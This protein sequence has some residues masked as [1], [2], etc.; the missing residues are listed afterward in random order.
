VTEGDILDQLSKFK[1]NTRAWA[2]LWILNGMPW[3]DDK[4]PPYPKEHHVITESLKSFRKS[5]LNAPEEVMARVK[6]AVTT[7]QEEAPIATVV[8]LQ[9]ASV[10]ATQLIANYIK[11]RNKIAELKEAFKTRATPIL[12]L[13]QKIEGL[14][15][16]EIDK[17]GSG[18]GGSL[19]TDNGTAFTQVE[20]SATVEDWAT[21]LKH[22]QKHELWELLE[23]RVAKGAVLA[24]IEE[25]RQ[26]VEARL[27]TGAI[28]KEE[29]TEEIKR[30]LVPG[31]K[32]SQMRVLRVRTA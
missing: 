23:R 1:S 9:T 31:V 22:I 15:M 29:A 24:N 21:T 7:Q 4:H 10:N 13:Q 17:L 8:E 5:L 6:K 20:T 28:T 12:E 11:L 16:I 30:A 25:M 14:L 27:A 19:R 3:Q 2:V 26:S 18:G 32:V